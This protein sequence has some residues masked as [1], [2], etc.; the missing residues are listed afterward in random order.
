MTLL[1]P[2]LK[3]ALAALILLAGCAPHVAQI[4]EPLELSYSGDLPAAVGALDK[5]PLATSDRNRFLYHVQRGHL[6][7]LAAEWEASNREFELAAAAA[8]ELAPA[9]LS[10]TAADYT[11]NENVKAYSG[12]D[13]E[14]AYVHY[15]VAL[16]YL[17]LGDR[18]GAL[19]ECRR[20]DEVFR[21]LDARYEE[22]TRRYEEDGFIRYL[23]ALVYESEGKLDDARVDYELALRAYE[24]DA[25]RAIGVGVPD[26]L[27]RSLAEYDEFR[28]AGRLR[29]GAGADRA[30]LAQ[31]GEIV[32]VID[33]GWAPFKV[34]KS[35]EVPIY[36]P[37]VP[38]ELRGTS[39]LAAVVKI[40]YPE[41]ES[42]WQ[43]PGGFLVGATPVDGSSVARDAWAERTQDMDALAQWTLQRRIGFVKLRSTL[44][45]TMKQIALATAKHEE[46]KRRGQDTDRPFSSPSGEGSV[47]AWILGWIIE[48]VATRAVAETEVADT[49]SWVTLPAEMWLARIQVDPGEYE[50]S[51]QPSGAAAPVVLGRVTV[52]PGGK[53]FRVARVFG[54][55]HPVRCD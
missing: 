7:H 36:R 42:V 16:N 43:K 39:N 38:E 48:D 11:I 5:S 44:R 9:S 15:Y 54:G 18:E 29:P 47:W 33:S 4:C 31:P 37:F 27:V 25:G 14:R 24:G 23:A 41:F 52:P 19:V 26:G 34:E 22:G 3:L 8:A 21:E 10:G 46:A 35:I 1:G 6:L 45:A 30:G 40:A 32:I 12:E 2:R 53:A 55:P 51:I 49:R 20:L 13:F 50:V 28:D 17:M